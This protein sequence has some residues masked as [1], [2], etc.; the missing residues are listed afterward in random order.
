MDISIPFEIGDLVYEIRLIT[1]KRESCE[2]CDGK[3]GSER[4]DGM[5]YYNVGCS[6]CSGKGTWTTKVTPYWETQ[7]PERVT[8][9]SLTLNQI[10]ISTDKFD[11]GAFSTSIPINQ[12]FKTKSAADKACKK[13]NKKLEEAR[14]MLYTNGRGI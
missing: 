8:R 3:G 10:S 4:C 5:G 13:F 11:L 6:K 9:I 14:K 7:K 12:A 2:S 1:S